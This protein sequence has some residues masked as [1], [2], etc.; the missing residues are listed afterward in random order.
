VVKN[1]TLAPLPVSLTVE[2]TPAGTVWWKDQPLGATGTALN[3]PPGR[4]SLLVRSPGYRDHGLEADLT[5]GKAATL[6]PL[7]LVWDT[8]SLRVAIEL[9][10]G[11]TRPHTLPSFT[12]EIRIDDRPWQAF[13]SPFDLTDVPS[14]QHRLSLRLPGYQDVNDREF[15]I[16]FGKKTNIVVAM[17]PL[18]AR[19]TELSVL[20]SLQEGQTT[21]VA[22]AAPDEE[23]RK[24][25]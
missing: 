1:V 22:A 19:S 14:G 10:Q 16:E 25:I 4:H 20:R 23:S 5:D 17:T 24:R 6:G 21:F 12:G 2:S 18:P 13:V 7:Q 11:F 9:A 8:G 15:R 3:L